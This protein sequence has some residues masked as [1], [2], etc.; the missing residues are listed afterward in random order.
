MSSIETMKNT[1]SFWYTYV[2]LCVPYMP[3]TCPYTSLMCLLHTPIG[4][5]WHAYHVPDWLMVSITV[6]Q[7]TGID[8]PNLHKI[9]IF[10]FNIS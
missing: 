9:L 7:I 6:N 8:W 4:P 5:L 3:H 10:S 1:N 2:P